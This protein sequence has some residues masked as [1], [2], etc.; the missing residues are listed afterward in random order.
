[1]TQMSQIFNVPVVSDA[2]CVS[3]PSLK[4]VTMTGEWPYVASS[5]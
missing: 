5:F 1:M 4:H 2:I 3:S